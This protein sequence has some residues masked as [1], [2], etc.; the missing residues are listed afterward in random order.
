MDE[1]IKARIEKTEEVL[2][3]G[4]G[5]DIMTYLKVLDMLRDDYEKVEIKEKAISTS[6]KIIETID[7]I[8]KKDIK[9]EEINIIM[10]N[11]YDTL[12]R[13][14]DFEAFMIAMEWNRPIKSQFF[15]PRR[16]ILKKHGFIQGIQDLLDRKISP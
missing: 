13:N 8:D 16:R 5:K 11:S 9:S 15:L 6:K 10:R 7:N 2:K 4:Q 3:N 12:A 14:G 1:E